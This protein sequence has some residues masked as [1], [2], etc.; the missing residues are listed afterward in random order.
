MVGSAYIENLLSDPESGMEP[1]A[2]MILDVVQG[3]AGAIPAPDEWVQEMRRITHER[4]IPE[5]NQSLPF[6][7][8]KESWDLWQKCRVEHSAKPQDSVGFI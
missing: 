3:E 6:S 8:P 7:A 5:T 1:P 2:R 4:H